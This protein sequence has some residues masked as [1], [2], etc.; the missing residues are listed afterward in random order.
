MSCFLTLRQDN[1]DLVLVEVTRM[2]RSETG[3]IVAV[4][5]IDAAGVLHAITP[6]NI[7]FAED[8]QSA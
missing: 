4:E 3:K 1:G 5:G 6:D 8:K 7:V 2:M